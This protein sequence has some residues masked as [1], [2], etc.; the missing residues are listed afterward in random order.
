MRLNSK[1]IG[2]L[3]S[4]LGALMSSLAW[5]Q[6]YPSRTVRMI[7]PVPAGG[8]YDMVARTIGQKLAERLGQAFIV[9]NRVGAGGLTGTAYAATTAADGY[10]LLVNGTGGLAIFPSL[11]A[12]LPY[13]TLRDFAPI[14]L[15]SGV[16]QIA[17]VNPEVPAHNIAELVSLVRAKPGMP[18]ASNGVGTTMHLATE[19]FAIETGTQFTHV[20]YNGSAP[21]V[22]SV[23]GGQ[24]QLLF[25]VATD[26]IQQVRAGKLRPLAVSTAKRMKA[27]PE[28]P[29]LAEAGVPGIVVEIWGGMLAPKGTPREIVLRLNAESNRALELPDVR[30][31]FSPG[32]IGDVKG[33]T[34]EHFEE[35]IRSEIAMWAK[36]V[37]ASGAKAE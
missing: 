25:A 12:K 29:T 28:V 20:P 27:L 1:A 18:Y 36:V 21:A 13:D 14:I 19:M 33:G 11:Y 6:T 23:L 22:T 10:S 9:E 8:Y 17:V 7:V 3:M 35:F 31:R 4:V 24:T 32:G 37:K 30:E 34:P 15:T 2:V 16:P 5:G 26:V